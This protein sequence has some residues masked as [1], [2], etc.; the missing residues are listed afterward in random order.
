MLA[1]QL[2]PTEIQADVSEP[3]AGAGMTRASVVTAF[4]AAGVL[5]LVFGLADVGV[6]TVM[7][8]P[9]DTPHL[10]AVTLAIGLGCA[11]IAIG[12]FLDLRSGRRLKMRAKKISV[13]SH[14]LEFTRMDGR[15]I[16]ASWRDPSLR[17]TIQTPHPSEPAAP[18]VLHYGAGRLSTNGWITRIGSTLIEAEAARSGLIIES[19]SGAAGPSILIRPK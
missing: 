17:L 11:L 12:I 9:S 13:S 18:L 15:V 4:V 5:I 2:G 8:G 7:P 10:V 1:G 14:G 6:S 3:L 16:V 19:E